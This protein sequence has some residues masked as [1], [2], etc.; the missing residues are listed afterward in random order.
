MKHSTRGAAKVSAVWLIAI[1]VLFFVAVAFAFI[2]QKDKTAEA[3]ARQAAETAEE[4][5]QT[6]REEIRRQV[7]EISRRLG[8]FSPEASFKVTNVE[9]AD[10]ALL[11]TRDD[12]GFAST[13]DTY[14]KLLPEVRAVRQSHLQEIQTLRQ[15][16]T[17]LEGD[18][19]AQRS[20]A[21]QVA[22]D[23]DSKIRE[24]TQQLEDEQTNGATR[25]QQLEEARQR[26]TDQVAASDK[27]VRELRLEIER[28]NGEHEAEL[29]GYVARFDQLVADQAPFKEPYSQLTDARVL[30]SSPKL[31]LGWIDIGAQNRLALGT[32]F[33][34]FAGGPAMG[35]LGHGHF[36]G[37]AEVTLTE[38]DKAQVRFLDVVDPYDPIVSGDHLVNALYDPHVEHNAILVGSFYGEYNEKELGLLLE[39]I[40]IHVQDSPD[41]TTHYVIV[42]NQVYVDEDGEPL[43]EP[44]KP[45]ELPAYRDAEAQGAVVIPLADLKTYF[46]M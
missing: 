2:A 25:Q 17:T 27:E 9:S 22:D 46:K 15:R 33:E 41:V 11:D 21:Q 45:T 32:V 23:K 1:L 16:I 38:P 13:I 19:D 39:K 20:A 4:A 14:E 26:L 28:L 42:G 31:S 37:R 44:M 30:E 6:S 10:Q 24:L 3:V 5:A 8:F 12:Y 35:D 36:K 40:G 18:V 29:R 7:D 43:E 34:V